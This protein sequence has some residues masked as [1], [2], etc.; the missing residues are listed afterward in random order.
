MGNGEGAEIRG[1]IHGTAMKSKY[2]RVT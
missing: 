2:P 1:A